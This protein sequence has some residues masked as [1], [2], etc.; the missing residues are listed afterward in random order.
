MT[1]RLIF[2]ERVERFSDARGF[3][4]LRPAGD[5]E[6][7]ELAALHHPTRMLAAGRQLDALQ[8]EGFLAAVSV[9][10]RRGWHGLCSVRV[11]FS[12]VPFRPSLLG[13]QL[14]ELLHPCDELL[15]RLIVCLSKGE[16]ILV[17]PAATKVAIE[18]CF[19]FL[20]FYSLHLFARSGSFSHYNDYSRR[21]FVLQ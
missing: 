9:A 15:V 1:L 13:Q 21:V 16:L 19:C 6:L 12:R 14:N 11:V 17:S 18:R 20:H 4:R 10:V 3:Q 7:L 8:F 2:L 5:A